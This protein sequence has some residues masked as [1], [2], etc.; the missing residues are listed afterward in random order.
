[1][2]YSTIILAALAS[3]ASA[4]SSLSFPS[5]SAPSKPTGSFSGGVL[6]TGT[7]GFAGQA[8]GTGKGSHSHGEHSGSAGSAVGT[9]VGN[10]Q[11]FPAGVSESGSG[12]TGAPSGG[13]G[14]KS[15]SAEETGKK[16]TG[17]ARRTKSAS[18]AARQASSDLPSG[19]GKPTGTPPS[20]SATYT[21]FSIRVFIRHNYENYLP[22][23]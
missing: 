1:M 15:G 3:S 4:Q 20:V 5:G 10:L 6:P 17:S 12:P 2:K 7:S 23:Y 21:N 11:T 8:A 14:G 19:S 13:F 22:N 16:P 18:I 9:G